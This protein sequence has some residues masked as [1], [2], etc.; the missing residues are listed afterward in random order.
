MR[1]V[2]VAGI[3]HS[4]ASFPALRSKVVSGQVRVAHKHLN[5]APPSQLL[6]HG[7]RRARLNVPRSPG[8][9]RV[10]PAAVFDG[11][12]FERIAPCTLACLRDGLSPAGEYS[13]RVFPNLTAQNTAS[14]PIERY[15]N[16][17]SGLRLLRMDPGA[18]TRQV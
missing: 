11:G 4:S 15:R 16:R 1:S 12:P 14:L 10:V 13:V 3:V 7:Q 6:Q 2:T 8:V 17:L 5:R 9:P 18:P